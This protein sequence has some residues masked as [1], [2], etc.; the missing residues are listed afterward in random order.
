MRNYEGQQCKIINIIL[1]LL[2]IKEEYFEKIAELDPLDVFNRTAGKS[3]KFQINY[4]NNFHLGYLKIRKN[5]IQCLKNITIN[6]SAQ[7]DTYLHAVF[8]LDKIIFHKKFLN[9]F[10]DENYNINNFFQRFQKN[11]DN[12]ENKQSN[13]NDDLEINQV[14]EEINFTYLSIFLALGTFSLSSMIT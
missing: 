14:T 11:N 10:R 6:Q 2:S 13:N 9:F 12:N 4:E 8:L 1:K 7:Q 5:I 3:T